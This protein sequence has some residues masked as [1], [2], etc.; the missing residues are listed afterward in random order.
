MSNQRKKGSQQRRKAPMTTPRVTNALC[1]FRADWGKIWLL[2]SRDLIWL[3]N[4][5]LKLAVRCLERVVVGTKNPPSA[6]RSLVA[7]SPLC[8]TIK[9]HQMI[10]RQNSSNHCLLEFIKSLPIRIHQRI[11][12]RNQSN[13]QNQN[14]NSPSHCPSE[15]IN[16]CQ[17]H[18]ILSSPIRF[19]QRIALQ[20]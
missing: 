17:S 13:F 12:Q 16:H 20:N 8:L 9:I 14:Q 7:S 19:N 5:K 4:T 11:T 10:A 18:L 2:K 6:R 1:S 15:L 3:I